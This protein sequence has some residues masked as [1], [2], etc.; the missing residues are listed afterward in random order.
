MRRA[1]TILVAVGLLVGILATPGTAAA[2]DLCG[3]T[4]TTDITL[5]ADLECDGP[6]LIVG[7]DGV[8]IDLGG[9]SIT[10]K[11][12][13]PGYVGGVGVLNPGY[14]N[15]TITNGAIRDFV[16][17]ILLENGTRD[18]TLSHLHVTA[19]GT[20]HT[21]WVEG[22]NSRHNVISHNVLKGTVHIS[23]AGETT[24]AHN[25]ISP[26]ATMVVVAL[27]GTSGTV[28]THNTIS[29]SLYG[30]DI[31]GASDTVLVHNEFLHIVLYG[32]E[33]AGGQTGTKIIKND[34]T[35]VG[36]DIFW[37]PG[38]EEPKIIPHR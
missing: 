13:I 4:V 8:T 28:L 33:L 34:F 12:A 37:N 10:R 14:D 23:D 29:N 2:P 9:H 6:G 17:G 22:S 19:L 27:D 16:Q 25:S 38:E 24:I 7:A 11:A 31:Y 21:V 5:T 32:M 18:N 35:D 3:S 20:Y 36:T 30:V 15:V 1:F 26:Y